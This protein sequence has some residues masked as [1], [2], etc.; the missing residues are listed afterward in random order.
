MAKTKEE[1]RE[2]NRDRYLANTEAI[3]ARVRAYAIAHKDEIRVKSKAHRDAN[4]EALQVKSKAYYEAHRDE[5]IAYQKALHEQKRDAVKSYKKKWTAENK[6]K[7]AAKRK[8]KRQHIAGVRKKWWERHY[9]VNRSQYIDRARRRRAVVRG[10][11]IGDVDI[12]KVLKDSKGLCGI[13]KKPLDLF[14]IDFD[15]IVPLARGGSHTQ[16]N[17]QA[18]HSY[19]NRAKGTKVG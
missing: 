12:S 10:A 18:T 17:L 2:Y 7:N 16:D 14:G 1:L 3:K 6:E 9:L 4:K 8:T 15:H 11:T 5:R 13:C 19:C